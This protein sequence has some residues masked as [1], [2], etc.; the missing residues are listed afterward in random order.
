MLIPLSY[1]ITQNGFCFRY[2]N[3][4]I[5]FCSICYFTYTSCLQIHQFSSLLVIFCVIFMLLS[6]VYLEHFMAL[7]LSCTNLDLKNIC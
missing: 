6:S 2:V 1:S 5:G 7:F 4:L 3:T